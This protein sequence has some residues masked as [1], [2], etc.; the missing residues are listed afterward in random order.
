MNVR[1]HIPAFVSGVDPAVAVVACQRELLD[2]EWIQRWVDDPNFKRWSLSH[3][4]E[5]NLLMAEMK[6]GRFWVIA[7]VDDVTG[8]DLPTWKHPTK[9][10]AV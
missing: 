4:G 10:R 7:F 3:D 2:L 1:Q 8:L 6:D 5:R 9:S